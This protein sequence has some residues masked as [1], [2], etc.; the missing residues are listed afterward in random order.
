MKSPP[1]LN[2][3]GDY[4]L[5]QH[6]TVEYLGCYLDSNLNRES[7]ARRVL[8]KINTKLNFLWKQCIYLKYSSRRLLCNALV[9]PH[10]DYGCTSWYPLLRVRPWKLN[11]KLLKAKAYVLAWSCHLVV[12]IN[13]SNF[14]K[15]NWLPV[16]H[17]VELC[18]ST[19]VF[20]KGIV[21]SYL[22][23]IFM[24]SI[25][26]YNT[27]S[28]MALEKLLCRTIK[29]QKSMSFLGPK[30]WNKVSSNKKQLQ[31]HLLS[32]TVWKKEF[33][34]NCKSEQF[35]WWFFLLLLLLLFFF[36]FFES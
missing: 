27:R 36:W 4:S 9:Q 2:I 29:W 7:M 6:N 13:P 24:L 34:V 10:F 1:K 15:I 8:K 5:K 28:Q 22:N 12:I 25:I 32:G 21:P 14:R 18:T 35:Y 11:C 33:L 17:R 31:P 16:E 23:D 26:N 19:T 3:Y 20:R 30:I